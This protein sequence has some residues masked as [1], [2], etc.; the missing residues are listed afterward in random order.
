METLIQS[1]LRQEYCIALIK[2]SAILIQCMG[3][4]AQEHSLLKT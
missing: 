3:F 4:T 1:E 2:T